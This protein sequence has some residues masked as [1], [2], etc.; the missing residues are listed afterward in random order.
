MQRFKNYII[1]GS[2][3]FLTLFVGYTIWLISKPIPLEIQGEVEATQVKVASKIAGRIDSLPIHKGQA[4][5]AGEVLFRIESPEL[6]AKLKQAC[7][8][9]RAAE[10]QNSKAIGGARTEDIQAAFNNWKKAEA[11][12]NIANKTYTRVNNLYADGVVAEQKRDEAEAQ[13]LAAIETE[14]AAKAQYTKAI[15]GTQREDKMA[16]GAMVDQAKG[17]ILEVTAYLNE[18]FIKT[19]IS[20][21][22]ANIIAER[23]ELIPAGY[24]V[25]TIVDL[26]DVW[27]TFNL[28]EDLL[29]DIEMG[30]QFMANV[31]ALGNKEILLEVSY[32]IRF[33]QRLQ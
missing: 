32:M 18:T 19:P 13:M 3:I 27:V 21:E 23:G 16:A 29:A 11:G 1:I 24:P 7:A 4:V 6:E 30:T 2:A 22:I 15:N 12:A 17:V 5:L 8:V 28:R 20:G 14:K 33:C 26:N 10:A 25:V 9:E 31:P